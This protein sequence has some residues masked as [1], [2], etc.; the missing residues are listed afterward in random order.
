MPGGRRPDVV[1]RGPVVDGGQHPRVPGV[2]GVLALPRA[3][4]RRLLVPV[5]QPHRG[6]LVAPA[7]VGS[8]GVVPTVQVGVQTGPRVATGGA[9][10]GRRRTVVR[11]GRLRAQ[12][13][14]EARQVR[15]GCRVRV[16]GGD[17]DRA[18]RLGEV[19]VAV[20]GVL[21]PADAVHHRHR[22]PAPERGRAG[23]GVGDGGRPRVHVGGRGRLVAVQDLGREVARGAQ[24]PAGVGQLRVV[25]DAGQ[26]EVDQDRGAALHQHVGRLHVAVQHAGAVHAG[27]P[28]GQ[29]AGEPGQVTTGHLAVL[30]HVVVQ[31]QA[32]HVAGRDVRHLG[33]RVGVDDLGDPAAADPAERGDLAGQARPGLLVAHHVGA[34]HLQ[35]DPVLPGAAG[36][37]HH[38]H[39]ALADLDDQLVV[40]DAGPHRWRGSGRGHA[41]RI[42]AADPG[43][44][45]R[46]GRVAGRRPADVTSPRRAGRGAACLPPCGRRTRAAPPPRSSRPR[47]RT[48]RGPARPS[49]TVRSRPG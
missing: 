25:G 14:Q 6:R 45:Q 41:T 2:T 35:R 39:P 8:V 1:R 13:V 26:A 29:A 44:A 17:D 27:Q 38:A 22:R 19:G 34:Q 46:R 24:Q 3:V 21:T 18:Q 11:S 9:Q 42:S 28:L 36:Q 49:R 32:G 33:P 23:R 16:Q 47:A 30:Q 4:Q 37:V 31:R 5:V 40:T 20:E 7:V 48:R 10:R 43:G 12:P 15:T